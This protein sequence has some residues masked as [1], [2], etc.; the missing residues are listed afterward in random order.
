VDLD[1]GTPSHD[2]F[3]R[4]FRLLDPPAFEAAFRAFTGAFAATLESQGVA[5]P[6]IAIDGQSLRGAVDTARRTMPLH[7]ITAWAADHRLVL[8][9]C[10]A[11]NR[12]EVTAA[13]KIIALLDL[14]GCTVTA[15][16]LHSSRQTLSAIRARGG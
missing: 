4:V 6:S 11:P 14:T 5:G 2:T 1:R 3:S 13:R 10:R 8:S 15:D 9:Q 16:A 7:L 12:S